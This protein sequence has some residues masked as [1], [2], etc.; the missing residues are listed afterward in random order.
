MTGQE[1][2]VFKNK[3]NSLVDEILVHQGYGEIRIDIKW[4]KQGH[5]EVIVTAGKQYRF[6]VPVDSN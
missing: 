6:V 4:V 5:K 1:L 2:V 3:L